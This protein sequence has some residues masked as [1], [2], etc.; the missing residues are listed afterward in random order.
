M[1]DNIFEYNFVYDVIGISKEEAPVVSQ[2][3]FNN[4]NLIRLYSVGD[5]W[6]LYNKAIK[7]EEV[8]NHYLKLYEKISMGQIGGIGAHPWILFSNTELFEGY[9]LFLEYLKAQNNC[10]VTSAISLVSEISKVNR[11]K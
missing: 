5:D 6:S 11:N 8:F 4:K 10:M 1:L 2:I 3:T 9:K 7:K